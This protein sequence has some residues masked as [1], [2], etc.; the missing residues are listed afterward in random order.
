L[1]GENVIQQDVINI[2]IKLKKSL[3]DNFQAD[4]KEALFSG[5]MMLDVKTDENW[6]IYLDLSEGSDVNL[7]LA[8]LNLLLTGGISPEERKNLRYIDLRPKDRAIICDNDIC[9]K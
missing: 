9:G 8:K 3:Q 4:I 1:A 2:L 6:H 5:P 7:E